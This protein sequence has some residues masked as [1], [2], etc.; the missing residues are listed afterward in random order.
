MFEIDFVNLLRLLLWL[1]V[2]TSFVVP[3]GQEAV[4]L[5]DHQLIILGNLSLIVSS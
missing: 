3:P 1:V 4:V 2:E 5:T